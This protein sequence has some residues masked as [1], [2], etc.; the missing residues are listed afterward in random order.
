MINLK[1]KIFNSPSFIN[2]PIEKVNKYDIQITGLSGSLRSFL[3]CYLQEKLKHPIVFISLN[4]ESAEKLFEDIQQILPE[5]HSRFIPKIEN[6]PYDEKAFNPSLLKLKADALQSLV[7][8]DTGITVITCNALI[9]K[10]LSP[11]N[12]VDNQI[13]LEKGKEVDFN[14]LI[15]VLINSGF[16]RK[17]IVED[18]GQLSV[19]GGIIDVYTWNYDEPLRLEF[20]G[21]QLESIRHFNIISQRSTNETDKV[22]ILPSLVKGN[23]SSSIFDYINSNSVFIVEDK[24]AIFESLKE[25]DSIVNQVYSSHLDQDIFLDKPSD[26][27]LSFEQI[28]SYLKNKKLLRLDLLSNEKVESY[29]FDSSP[30]PT[31]TANINRFISY[32]LKNENLKNEIHI[33]CDTEG[34]RDRLIEILEEEE[35]KDKNYYSIISVGSLHNGFILNDINLHILTDHE[36]FDRFKRQ[37]IYKRFK[38]GEYLRSLKSLSLDDYV[39]HIDYG[40]GKYRGLSVIGSNEIKKECIKVEFAEGDNLFVSVD[41]LNRVQKFKTDGE[42]EPKLTKLG[43]GEWEKLKNKTKESVQ[44]I[45]AELLQ[46]YAERKSKQGFAFS[47]DNHWQKELEASFPFEETEDQ[48]RSIFEVKEDLEKP[49]PM[50]RL[51]CGDV[52][53][54]KTE[55]ALRSAFK[56]VNDGKQVAILVPT[57]ILAYQHYQTFKERL[58]SFPVNIEMLSRFRTKKIQKDSIEKLEKGLIDI[59]IGTHR[60]LSDDVKFKDLGLLV[61]DEEQ[62]FGVKHKEKLKKLKVTVDV[63]TMT[64]TPIPRTMHL[65]LMGSRDLSHI[66]TPPRNRLPVI[67][68]IHEWNEEFIRQIIQR[69]LDRNGQVYFVHNRVKTIS[70]IEGI[71]ESLLPQARV[72]VGH[73]QL[74]E[75]QLE[76]I[77]LDFIHKKYDVLISTM[78]IENGLDIPNVNTIIIDHADKFGLAQLYQLR[79]RVGRSDK[80]AYAYLFIKNHSRLNELSKKRLRAIQDF[81]ELGSGFKLALRDLE[82]RGAGNILGKEQSGYIQSVGFDLYCKILDETVSKLKSEKNITETNLNIKRTTDPKI[83]VDYDLII[84]KD[85]IFDETE[86][87]TIY[88]RLVNLSSMEQIEKLKTEITDRFGQLPV[89][90]DQLINTIELKVLA[91]Q[92]FASH[93]I[94]KQNTLKMYF[95]EEVQKFDSFFSEIIPKFMKETKAKIQFI[96]KPDK[97]GIEIKLSG[98]NISE[99]INFAKN[100]LKY[101]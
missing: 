79:G 16:D 14:E 47:E 50:D 42:A 92:L 32:V 97:L 76:K 46:L 17:E 20:F 52:G 24:I 69:E 80:Q 55:V 36:I 59:V 4:S 11:E 61:I 9:E 3:I 64:A 94:L 26:R 78:I 28:E 70:G 72:A 65:S 83:D 45:A 90:V 84:P 98:N 7:E 91:G 19:R 62:R 74:P 82:I 86:R 12:L 2:F 48:M 73:G 75:T 68:E 37:K 27:Y 95:S 22:T 5:Q 51:L 39:V 99:K 88:H 81:T 56:V 21:D 60:L 43:T 87:I 10:S 15:E 35:S 53:Y 29:K 25:Y 100:I 49:E 85:Y 41:R 44:I 67:T 40:I 18:V 34:Q 71:I 63:L 1:N 30:P 38:N 89:K 33:Q 96:N 8:S 13:Y 58:S 77:M 66:E 57:T 93:L 23:Q 54:G 101:I 31:F 6:N